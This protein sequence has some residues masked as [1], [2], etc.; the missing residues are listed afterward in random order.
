MTPSTGRPDAT[1]RIGTAGWSVPKGGEGSQLQR[2]AALLSCVEI[3]SSFYRP[4]RPQTYARWAASVPPDFRFA[5]KAPRAITHE[6]RLRDA[7]PLLGAFLEQIAALGPAL[8]PVLVQLPPSLSYNPDLAESFFAD[9]RGLFGGQAVVEP[10]HPSWFGEEAEALLRAYEI[11]R[12]AADPAPTPQADEPGG[13]SGL[14][15]WRWHGSPQMYHSAYGEERLRP[16]ARPARAGR[17]ARV[18]QHGLR[19]RFAGCAAAAAPDLGMSGGPLPPAPGRTFAL[20]RAG[21]RLMK[22]VEPCL[23]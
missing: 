7:T 23:F 16:L 4:H 10:R 1:Y 15:Y 18:R 14:R 12:V 8:G 20:A 5:V 17:L 9:L 21:E 3:N 13:W 11:G 19:R 22:A 6:A 2:Y